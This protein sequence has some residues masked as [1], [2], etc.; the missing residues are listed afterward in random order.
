MQQR[1]RALAAAIGLILA[2]SVQAEEAPPATETTTERHPSLDLEGPAIDDFQQAAVLPSQ[3]SHLPL[4][5]A[6]LLKHAPGAA[7]NKNGPLT[8]ISQY[9]GMSASRVNTLVDGLNVSPACPNWMDPP[10]SFIPTS[11]LH[12]V[13]VDR[14]I[15]P[16]SAGSESI[17][18]TIRANGR[19]GTFGTGKNFEPHGIIGVGGQ[20]IDSG[21]NGNALLWLSND[22]HR[23]QVGPAIAFHRTAANMVRGLGFCQADPTNPTCVPLQFTNVDAEFYGVDAGFGVAVTDSWRIDGNLSY[24]RGKRRDIDDDLYRIAPLNGILDLTYL[25]TKWSVTAEGEFF[26]KQDDVSRTNA[27]EKTDGY[28]LLNLYGQYT[29]NDSLK[30]R[31]GARNVFDSFYQSHISGIN[32]VAADGDGDPVDLDLGERLPGRGR[33]LFVRVEY[34]F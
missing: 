2:G 30:I 1:N 15:S 9:R 17:G 24:V 31:A 11:E 20:T 12:G 18:G 3:Q 10:L 28:A 22:R 8:G 14:G 23:F 5:P 16:V 19:K 33:S 7:V 27:E 32:R 21:Y 26:A 4:D 34:R 25:G 6:D 13:V 29:F